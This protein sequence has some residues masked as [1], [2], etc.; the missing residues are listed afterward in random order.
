MIRSFYQH[1]PIGVI[2]VLF[3]ILVYPNIF[4]SDYVNLTTS[5]PFQRVVFFTHMCFFVIIASVHSAK[6]D[7][8][9]RLSQHK[10]IQA[11]ACYVEKDYV[12]LLITECYKLIFLETWLWKKIVTIMLS[13][14]QLFSLFQHLI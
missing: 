8:S 7:I 3:N 11:M 14:L 10:L 2:Y 6:F 1:L 5:N 9:S 4:G 13:A 12:F